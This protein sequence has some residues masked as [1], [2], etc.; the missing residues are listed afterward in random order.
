MQFIHDKETDTLNVLPLLPASRQ[1]VPVFWNTNDQVPLKNNKQRQIDTQRAKFWS[2]LTSLRSLKSTLVSPVSMTTL[3]PRCWPN[4]CPQ[5]AYLCK[6]RRLHYMP[7]QVTKSCDS[8]ST[9]AKSC[10]PLSNHVT[11]WWS[12][13]KSC[14]SIT[15]CQVRQHS[16]L[17]SQLATPPPVTPSPPPCVT[18]PLSSYDKSFDLRHRMPS[19]VTLSP[20]DK[21]CVSLY[22]LLSQLASPPPCHYDLRHLMPS[23]VTL[24]HDLPRQRVPGEV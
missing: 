15:T 2:D 10:D 22:F 20:H 3:F 21:S 12:R 19:H 17:L 16:F 11:L 7:S 1:H 4:F 6:T 18:L 9:H 13:T 8:L 24:P 5:S 14:D 23:H